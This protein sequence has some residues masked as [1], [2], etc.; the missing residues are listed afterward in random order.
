M[1]AIQQHFAGLGRDPTDCELETLAQTWSEHCSHKTLRGRIEFEGR[2]IDNLLKQT[3]FAAT[4]DLDL[5]WLVSVFADNAG[6]SGST[7][8][9]TSASRSRRTTIPR[10]SIP[11]AGSNTG[12]GGVIR[13]AARHRA[14]GPSRSATPTSS[15]WPRPT[16]HPIGFPTGVLHPK[17]VLKG[18]VAGVRD[19]GNRMGI[20]DRQRGPGGRSRLPGQ[21]PG[22]LR[23]GRRAAPGHVGEARRA[24]RPDHR[25]RRPDRPRRHPRGHV[26]LGRADRRERDAS[27]A[28]RCRSATRSPRRW[29]STSIV[30]ARDRGLFRSITDCGA[31][32]F[33]SAVGEMGAELGAEVDLESRPAQVSRAF[34]H[35]DLD[36]RGPGA[37]GPGRPPREVAGAPGA[38]R[39]AR[40]SRPP[41][42]ASSSTPA[43]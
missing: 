16:W 37:D 41:T 25:H 28:A 18:V 27:P 36:L 6:S 15:A 7:T 20:P 12:L 39:D 10:R 24:R 8:S 29:S 17:R 1:K 40:R 22:L 33:S 14:S 42:S 4:R 34:L 9:T 13:D 23:H 11:T 38:L 31:G 19:Y 3:I 5:D 43:G 2:T 32:G 26:Q 30:Q 21:S 35:R